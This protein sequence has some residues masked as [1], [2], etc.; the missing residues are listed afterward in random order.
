[1]KHQ[2]LHKLSR[3]LFLALAC[4]FLAAGQ[5]TAQTTIGRQLVDQFPTTAWS[6]MTYGLTWLPTDYSSNT[7]EKYPLIIFLH[8]SGEGGD[9]VNGLWNL[10]SQGLPQRIAMGWNPEAVN[11]TDGK[12]YKFIVV[13]PQAP[14]AARW[15]YG[16]GQLPYILY[17]VVH[18]YRV[19][20]SRIYVTGLSAGGAGAWACVTNTPEFAKQFAAIV[21]VDAAGTNTPGEQANLPLVG[22]TYDVK[23]WNVCGAND[24]WYSFAQ[25]ATA[26]INGAT[27]SPA[28]PAILT[29][30]PG[31]GHEPNAWNMPYDPSWRNNAQGLNTFEWMLKYKRGAGSPSTPSAPAANQ[32][33]TANA[34]ADQTITLP[35]STATLSGIGTDLDGTIASYSWARISGPST[36]AFSNANAAQCTLSGLVQGTYVL[37]LT[38]TDN[39]GATAT[40]DVNI[41]VNAAPVVNYLAVPGR[42]EAEAYSSM[43]GIQTENSGDVGGTQNVGWQE[44]G[45]WMDY[46]VNV[47]T[48][49]SYTVSF[50]AATTNTGVQVQL[51][52]AAG[53]TLGTVTIPNTG[54]WQTYQTVTATVTLPAGQQTLRV[55]TSDAKGTG[56]NFNWMEFAAATVAAT[57]PPSAPAPTTPTTTT[58]HIEAEAYSNMYGIQTENSGDAGGTLNVGWQE[59]GDWMDYSVNVAA[60]GTYTVSFRVATV[61]T[62]VQVQL[63]NASGTT[64][65]TVTVPNT[66]WWQTYQTVTTTVTLPAG[67]QTLRIYTSDAK[68]SG[69]NFNWWEL[70]GPATT[71][72]PTPPVTTFTQRIEAEAYS[73]MYGIQ[74]EN[75]GDA[76]GTLNV[77]WQE[78]GDWMDYSVNIPSAGTYT[79]N[80]RVATVNT[81][82]QAQLR[83]AAGTTLTTITVPNTGWWQT[84]QTVSAQV[85][86][87]AG[88]QT[89]RIYTSDA[90]GS[91]WNFNWWEITNATTRSAGVDDVITRT[92]LTTAEV[93]PAQIT[94]RFAL[95]VDNK[96]TGTMS[97]DVVDAQ[98]NVKKSFTVNKA[99]TGAIQTYL[100]VSDLAAGQYTLRVSMNGWNGSTNFEKL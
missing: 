50:R 7:T 48:A 100:S 3:S 36:P 57:P 21:P 68:G 8:G 91:G 92:D 83:N 24:A 41:T 14:S 74:T 40:D 77:G 54:W 47:A 6:T 38:V 30:I 90:K 64:L 22:G 20:T 28:T 46:S 27:P 44:T 49:G 88:Q 82:V 86:L 60:A 95:K 2:P 4:S 43:S 31:L 13:S 93:F 33:P 37:R 12:N 99:A 96:L 10:I 45:D 39:K 26:T 61:N 35:T 80:F 15:S 32:P 70:A 76:G 79:V 97:I 42:V 34:G 58:T 1:M 25:Q 19:D 17:D 87:P 29:G 72:T 71:T 53:S 16:Y 52:N 75:T 9:G 69:W 73:T 94:S 67:Q 65:G 55:Y 18:R 78:T 56:W 66:G 89:L 84:Y 62:G 5:L 11:P 59:N 63:R 23:V 51:R 85:T 81:G 98:G